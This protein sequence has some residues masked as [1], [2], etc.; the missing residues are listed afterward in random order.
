MIKFNY[1]SAQKAF[2]AIMDLGIS[3]I[4]GAGMVSSSKDHKAAMSEGK[5]G[6]ETAH[7]SI[8]EQEKRLD[9]LEKSFGLPGA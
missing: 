3:G 1:K 7:K 6:L 2:G 8:R 4:T 5:E 9:Q